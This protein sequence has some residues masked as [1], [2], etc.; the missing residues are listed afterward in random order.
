MMIRLVTALGSALML[1]IVL[2]VAGGVLLY[3][4]LQ[5]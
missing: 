2:V 4:P 5:P 3:L 1:L